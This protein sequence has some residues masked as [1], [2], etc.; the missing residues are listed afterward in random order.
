MVLKHVL[1]KFLI[2]PNTGFLVVSISGTRKYPVQIS[3]LSGAYSI[4]VKLGD[5]F[6]V[7]LM[8]HCKF[9]LV[10]IGGCCANQTT[11]VGI[12]AWGFCVDAGPFLIIL[13]AVDMVRSSQ[14]KMLCE[15]LYD[16]VH[17]I[18]F[19]EKCNQ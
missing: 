2:L 9:S 18:T 19:F 10:V 7:H 1:R 4:L 11:L 13:I 14:V 6:P 12:V 5:S 15:P 3:T 8:R 17:T 16:V